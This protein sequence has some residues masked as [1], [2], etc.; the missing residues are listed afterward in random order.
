MDFLNLMKSRYTGKLYNPAKK[1]PAEDLAKLKEILRLTPSSVNSQPW[2]FIFGHTDADKDRIRPA[3]LDFNR[4]RVDTASDFVVICV[5]KELTEDHLQRLAEQEVS[6][7]RFTPEKMAAGGDAG[8]RSF[9]GMHQKQGDCLDWE[10]HQAYIAL[11]SALYGAA[12]LGID[13]TPI[14][15]F[16]AA[17]MDKLLGL[18]QHGLKSV[19]VVSFGYRST[20][21]RNAAAPKSRLPLDAVIR[22]ITDV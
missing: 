2:I 11:G 15:G 10:T 16:D 3:V 14:E 21:D 1:I 19:L 4:E 7:G 13:S 17:L 8:R 18:D 12:S 6:D 22:N 20:E 9:V 5:K